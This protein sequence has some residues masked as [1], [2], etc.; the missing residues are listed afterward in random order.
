MVPA[1]FSGGQLLNISIEYG[2]ITLL[3]VHALMTGRKEGLYRCIFQKI[4]E[5]APTLSPDILMA[6]YEAAIDS[7]MNT[8]FPDVR[9]TGC[10]FHYGQAILKK[11][12]AVGL[13]TEFINDPPVKKWGEKFIALC[14]LPSNLIRLELEF[15]KSEMNNQGNTQLKGKMRNFVQYFERY[16]MSQLLSYYQF[17][18]SV[19][20]LTMLVK[21]CTPK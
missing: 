3:V 4:K 21:H 9:L 1:V 13:Q 10:R 11:L 15:L 19:I 20:A 2:N 16:W 5:I 12:K 14:L 17:M 7:A 18:G 8:V 6:D